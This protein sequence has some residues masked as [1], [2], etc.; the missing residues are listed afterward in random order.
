MTL[1]NLSGQA[2]YIFEEPEFDVDRIVGVANIK[3]QDVG[4][5]A[6]LAMR[7]FEP[8]FASKIRPGSLLIGGRNFGYGH[9]HYPAM[10]AMRHLGI[11]GVIAESFFPV[12]WRGEISM[13]F[14]QIACHGILGMVERFDEIEVD[15]T[16]G[17]VRNLTR[18]RLLP[19]EP[20]S[21]ADREMLE[22]GGFNVWL[23]HAVAADR[24]AADHS[25]RE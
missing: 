2:A 25:K 7:D 23:R 13:G 16:G 4:Q 5:L 1:R 12:Y 10:R 21:Q 20:L 17:V 24:A 18:N 19:F 14:P 22:I 15:W 8:D 11:S 6:A 3:I 9:P